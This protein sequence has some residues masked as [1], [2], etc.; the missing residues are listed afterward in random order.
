MSKKT[1]IDAVKPVHATTQ[2]RDTKIM[3]VICNT[4]ILLMCML[5]EAFSDFFTNMAAGMATAVSTG[6]GASEKNTKEMTQKI[7]EI[8][9]ELPKQMTEQLITMKTDITKQLQSKK[10]DIKT[11]I[12]DPK[13][14]EGITIAEQYHFGLS[15]LTQDLDDLT[16]LKYIGL[17]TANDAQCVKMFQELMA[18]MNSIPQLKKS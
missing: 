17:L 5:T 1:N 4:S 6:F 9:T 2:D 14:D 8:K 11:L 15:P 13:F 7:D 10:D 16:L 3:N 12:I 18:W